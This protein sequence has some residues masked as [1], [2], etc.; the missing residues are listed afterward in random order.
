MNGLSWPS[1]MQLVA[2]KD[3]KTI[4]RRMAAVKVLECLGDRIEGI[5]ENSY[6]MQ[7]SLR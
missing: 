7:R 5:R 1:K 3:R 6:E 4:R 2:D